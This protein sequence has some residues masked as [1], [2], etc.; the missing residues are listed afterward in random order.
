MRPQYTVNDYLFEIWPLDT[1]SRKVILNEL[2]SIGLEYTEQ[3]TTMGTT[4]LQLSE[5]D[6]KQAKTHLSGVIVEQ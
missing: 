6:Y 1:W 5:A 2:D 4:S 3:F